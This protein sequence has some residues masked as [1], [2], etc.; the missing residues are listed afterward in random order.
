MATAEVKAMSP[1]EAAE[2]AYNTALKAHQ[3]VNSRVEFFAGQR[4]SL[5]QEIE[6]LQAQFDTA[7]RE[8][9][10]GNGVDPAPIAGELQT[11]KAKLYG[12]ELEHKQAV[13]EAE[14]LAKAA[15]KAGLTLSLRR[16][17]DELADLLK[18]EVEAAN[19]SREGL[20][21]ADELKRAHNAVNYEIGQLRKK[22]EALEAELKEVS[23][24]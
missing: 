20:Q 7:C 16:H 11:K 8:A 3:S 17:E 18:R 1:T 9:A 21:R 13:S 23:R 2:S 4:V 6:R 22:K 24:G 5:E 19:A 14:P 15:T 10:K 12:T